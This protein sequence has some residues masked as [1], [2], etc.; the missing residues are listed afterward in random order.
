MG[1]FWASAF[2][3]GQRVGLWL[4]CVAL[5]IAFWKSNENSLGM[6]PF[7]R[8][9]SG[10]VN[11]GFITISVLTLLW[12]AYAAR[13]RRAAFRALAVWGLVSAVV[14]LSKFVLG[15]VLHLFPRPSGGYDGFPSGHAAAACALAYLLTERLPR[16]APLW[17]GVAALI[18]WSRVEAGSHYAYQVLAGAILGIVVAI[19]FAQRFPDASPK[20]EITVSTAEPRTPTDPER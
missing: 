3:I 10:G 15:K 4:L 16:L 2:P 17:W 6:K 14:H 11:D 9:L 8:V 7:A 20:T 18:S 12:L 13:S 5:G 1:A 19:W